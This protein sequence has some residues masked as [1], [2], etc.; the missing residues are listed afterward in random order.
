MST[1][2]TIVQYFIHESISYH[3]QQDDMLNISYIN[4]FRITSNRT[5]CSTFF[6]QLYYVSLPTGQYMNDKL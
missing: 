2:Y 4:V 5:I 1:L 3:F 6:I